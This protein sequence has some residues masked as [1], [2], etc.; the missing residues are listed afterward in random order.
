VRSWLKLLLQKNISDYIIVRGKQKSQSTPRLR[1][2]FTVF[3]TL[4]R[5]ESAVESCFCIEMVQKLKCEAE[6]KSDCYFEKPVAKIREI[7]YHY[8]EVIYYD[9]NR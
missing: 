4:L 3:A 7:W 5:V 1:P 6:I 8:T 9:K 2:L